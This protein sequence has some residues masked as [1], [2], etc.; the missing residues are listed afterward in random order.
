MSASDRVNYPNVPGSGEIFTPEFLE[1]VVALHD[2]FDDSVQE[3]RADRLAVSQAAT[4]P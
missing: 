2:K 1:Y 4:Y 3:L